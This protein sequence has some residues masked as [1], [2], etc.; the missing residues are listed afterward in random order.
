MFFVL[1]KKV[2]ILLVWIWNDNYITECF[3][4]K[5]ISEFQMEKSFVREFTGFSNQNNSFLGT[6]SKNGLIRTFKDETDLG[7]YDFC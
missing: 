4:I 7:K 2:T 3:L 6:T 5:L 1:I